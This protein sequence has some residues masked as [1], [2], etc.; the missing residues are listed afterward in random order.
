MCQSSD[1]LQPVL[2]KALGAQKA[3]DALKRATK[4]ARLSVPERSVAEGVIRSVE[5]ALAEI[6]RG[7]SQIRLAAHRASQVYDVDAEG[8]TPV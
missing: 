7:A 1:A 6:E 2:Q 4:S 5:G 8:L 3:I